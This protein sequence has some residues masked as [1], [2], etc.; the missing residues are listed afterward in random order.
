M[1]CPCFLQ[2]S[3]SSSVRKERRRFSSTLNSSSDDSDVD[4]TT[5]PEDSTTSLSI[6]LKK[7]LIQTDTSNASD[8]RPRK[9]PL[10]IDPIDTHNAGFRSSLDTSNTFDTTASA[11]DTGNTVFGHQQLLSP[12]AKSL[13]VSINKETLGHSITH[14]H[15]KSKKRKTTPPA[16]PTTA[17]E[18]SWQGEE[19]ASPGHGGVASPGSYHVEVDKSSTK[20]IFRASGCGQLEESK[21]SKKHK[22]KAKHSKKKAKVDSR[23]RERRGSASQDTTGNVWFTESDP[24]KVKIK[25]E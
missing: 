16:P 1:Y 11:F 15:K 17:T 20:L 7:S 14:H 4:V 23:E 5:P 21:K 3:R 18:H 12:P 8:T 24:L 25:L 13:V 6:S 9:R 2:T 19:F 10:P 22:K